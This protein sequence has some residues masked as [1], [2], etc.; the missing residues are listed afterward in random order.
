MP[1]AGQL[2]TVASVHVP[3]PGTP[4]SNRAWAF[5]SATVATA[6][7]SAESDNRTGRKATTLMVPTL[8]GAATAGAAAQVGRPP[9]P[10]VT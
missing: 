10:V 4:A 6:L 2:T 7:T 1:V 5:A 3:V 8:G 9:R